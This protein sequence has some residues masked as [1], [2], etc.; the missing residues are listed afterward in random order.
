M[1]RHLAPA[2]R[3]ADA[4]EPLPGGEG[5]PDLVADHGRAVGQAPGVV[6]PPDRAGVGQVQPGQ[7]SQG[8]M[9][10]GHRPTGASP[11]PPAITLGYYAHFMPEAGSFCT[12]PK[13][14]V[15]RKAEQMGGLGKC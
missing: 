10:A 4:E 3:G 7:R 6:V 8:W 12:P 2:G 1:A 11:R 14:A 15:D 13:L 9:G 5:Q